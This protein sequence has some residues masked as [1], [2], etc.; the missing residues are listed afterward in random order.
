MDQAR[1]VSSGAR[2]PG[3]GRRA[4]DVAERSPGPE[5]GEGATAPQDIGDRDATQDRP[6][7]APL[8]GENVV[9]TP[10]GSREQY[11]NLELRKD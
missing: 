8:Y 3:P 5:P 2:G 11:G 9:D 1:R 4:R 7:S 10:N 6:F